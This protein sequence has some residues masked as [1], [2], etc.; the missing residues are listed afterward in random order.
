M[1]IETSAEERARRPV[2]PVWWWFLIHGLLAIAYGMVVLGTPF[3]DEAGF[4]VDGVAMATLSLLAGA[5]V[6]IQGVLSRPEP[7][8]GVLLVA[9]LHAM[10]AG[11]AF[12]VLAALGLRTALFWSIAS[13]L[14]VEGLV[15]ILGLWPAPVY[16]LWGVL[17]GGCMIVSAA[18]LAA[19]W[20][21]TPGHPYDIPDAGLGICG[22]LYGFAALVAA[23]QVRAAQYRDGLP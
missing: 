7:G 20:L 5:Q 18:T 6:A 16:R 23:L 14:V 2:K 9:G 11:V 15:L 19:L 3:A 12:A 17:L 8:W 10:A 21:A 4:L 1:S 22:L 13:F